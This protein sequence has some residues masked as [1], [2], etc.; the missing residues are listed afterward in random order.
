MATARQRGTAELRSSTPA[1]CAEQC[2][3]M[4]PED[5]RT[6]DRQIIDRLVDASLHREG[7][8]A[9]RR[10]VGV[11]HQY[12][13]DIVTPD[14]PDWLLDSAEQTAHEMRTSTDSSSDSTNTTERLSLV[15]STSSSSPASTGCWSSCTRAIHRHSTTAT[16]ERLSTTSWAGS[17][18][19]LGRSALMKLASP[20][21]SRV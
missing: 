16:K 18:A 19:G 11:W 8:I 1:G 2:R 3:A 14:T 21:R 13:D 4:P 7:Q 17:R 9:G 15:C 6:V 10:V 12:V 5:D 20:D